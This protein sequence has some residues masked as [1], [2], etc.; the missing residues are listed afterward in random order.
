MA[1]EN[2][3]PPAAAA[4]LADAR[5]AFATHLRAER[6]LSPHTVRAYLGDVDRLLAH[7]A[8]SG[9]LDPDDLTLAVLRRWLAL[10]RTTRHADSTIARRA[11]AAR[12]FTA[13][14]A[15]TGRARTDAGAG[16]SSPKVRRRLPG[17]L[18]HE[19]AEALM[20]APDLES[21]STGVRDRA[22]LE[23]LYASGLRVGE[24]VS[25]DIDDLDRARR[26]VR[27]IGKGDKER[28]VPIGAPAF[29]AIDAWLCR[30]RPQV[31]TADSGPALFLGVRGR[32]LDQRA[33]RTLMDRHLAGIEGVGKL[34]PHALRHT[35]A[36]HLLHGGADLRSVQELLGHATLTT[37]QIYTHVSV[38]RLRA[39]YEQAHPRA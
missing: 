25:L 23:L 18:T 19:Q 13:F 37:T 27:A 2:V 28:V 26:T 9:V 24:L 3:V 30:G 32:R 8:R 15:R 11:A 20:V 14:V 33:V 35:A 10:E 4:A 16:L 17:V 34:S 36:T 1:V 22:V 31:A 39:S 21:G 38:E 6:G 5:A 12:V 29:A 7:A